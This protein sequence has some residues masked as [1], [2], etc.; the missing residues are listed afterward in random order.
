DI[1]ALATGPIS[2]T[3]A[4][5]LSA[6]GLLSINGLLDA[7][8]QSVVLSGIGIDQTAAISAGSLVANGG[9]GAVLLT[10]GANSITGGLGGAAG[11]DF[12]FIN[13]GGFEVTG[14]TAGGTVAL[15]AQAGT[16]TQQV[17]GAIRAT[18][19]EARADGAG[20]G[21]VLTDTGNDV[22][23]LTGSAIGAGGAF[24]YVDANGFQVAGIGADGDV[25]LTAATGSITQ[26]AGL[27]GRISAAGLTATANAGSVTLDNATNAAA[28]LAG[29]AGTDFTYTG[30]S[31]FQVAGISAG[32]RVALSTAS[33]SITQA[34][35]A[36]A[37]IEAARLDAVAASG[38][39]VLDNSANA[40]SAVSG[41]A[42]GFGSR[43]IY[44]G[45]TGFDVAGVS[46]AAVTLRAE[47]GS[48]A[49]SAPIRAI[50]LTA[51]ALAGAVTL[52]DAGNRVGTLAGRTLGAGNDFTFVNSE[53]FAVA[54]IQAADRLDL[55]ANAGSITQ[56][57]PLSGTALV[58]N[59]PAG[60]VTLSDA[61][62][63]VATLSGASGGLFAYR[64][65]SELGVG[66]VASVGDLSL[67]AGLGLR[68][69]GNLSAPGRVVRLQ[70]GGALVQL[71]AS[72]ITAASLLA[73]GGGAVDLS[74]ST[75]NQFTTFAGRGSSVNL[76]TRNSLTIGTISGD[77]T[78]NG[79]A[80]QA[81][82]TADSAVRILVADPTQPSATRTL[83]VNAVV[84]APRI[85]LTLGTGAG[86]IVLADNVLRGA[87]GV[88]D[89]QVVMLDVTGRQ[90]PNSPDL[91]VLPTF[92]GSA[93]PPP[94]VP[95]P[96]RLGA[97]INAGLTLGTQVMNGTSLYLMLNGGTAT[98]GTNRLNVQGLAVYAP[99]PIGSTRIDFQNVTV[100]G[101]G[102][103]VAAT[104][105]G[106][107]I[108][109]SDQL[110]V[111]NCP[112]GTV[113]CVVLPQTTPNLP[114]FPE[115][116]QAGTLPPRID[117]STLTFINLGAEDTEDYE[118]ER[119]IAVGRPTRVQR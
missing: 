17:G 94:N 77:A 48:I 44:V 39:V 54:G 29:A 100:A 67:R 41:S 103:Q 53:G 78:V 117:E 61:G 56:T 47:T 49:Q 106:V 51:E 74:Q 71:P 116:L 5:A 10:D 85:Q 59:A 36:A 108:S 86:S 70:A 115:D 58:V 98:N 60:S 101:Q 55:R 23:T 62:N 30:D 45:G 81:G 2:S 34:A 28:R 63:D 82:V 15:G 16:I 33:G 119:R 19:L 8:G 18:A 80:P 22:A 97:N 99:N 1:D 114:R 79:G 66:N 89:A 46:G 14:I 64:D 109:P 12:R 87:G 43:F 68:V 57:A 111:N 65:A 21:V 69:N 13:L 50:D 26:A 6:G 96:I 35:G 52:G 76:S 112:I 27:G 88:G 72:T 24:N 75:S 93:G 92:A 110:R 7:T 9:A 102:G 4:V 31:P 90:V 83:S 95:I 20:G 37:R 91:L 3:G 11:I 42:A 118:D 32:N 38:D 84:G 40:V 105:S 104:Q 113:T 25:T 107:S 73:I